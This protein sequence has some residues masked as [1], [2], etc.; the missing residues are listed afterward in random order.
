MQQHQQIQS[1]QSAQND[2]AK[3]TVGTPIGTFGVFAS[4]GGLDL[5][6]GAS[7]QYTLDQQ[8]LEILQLL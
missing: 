3:L 4:E 7:C 1:L 2:D 8:M 5:E 6:D